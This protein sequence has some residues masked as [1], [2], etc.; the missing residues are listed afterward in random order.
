[1]SKQLQIFKCYY[2]S[3]FLKNITRPSLAVM[4]EE[5]ST[6]TE[7]ERTYHYDHYVTTGDF[8]KDFVYLCQL[9]NINLKVSRRLKIP[10]KTHEQI[11]PIPRPPSSTGM[12]KSANSKRRA[13]EKSSER[14]SAKTLPQNNTTTNAIAEPKEKF[15]YLRPKVEIITDFIENNQEIDKDEKK[16]KR[17]GIIDEVDLKG[18]YSSTLHLER[19]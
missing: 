14:L 2:F 8:E 16:S 12:P 19:I 6:A 17:K 13:S 7:E 5:V 15:G 9:V 11:H 3:L 10:P 18:V 1:M 4:L